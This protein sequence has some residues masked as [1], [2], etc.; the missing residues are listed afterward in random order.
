MRRFLV[1]L[2]AVLTFTPSAAAAPVFF[3]EGRGWGH[4]IGMPQYGAYGY[5]REEGR[6]YA[7]ILGHYYRGTTLG[8][9]SVDAVRVLLADDRRSLTV[10]SEAAFTAV[11][12]NGRELEFPAGRRVELAPDLRVTVAGDE[13]RLAG[14]VRFVRGERPL[15]LGGRPYRGQLVIRSSG[16]TLSA[17]NYVGLEEY[18]YGVVP[19][20]MPPEWPMEALKAQ[21]VAA[22]SYA[23]VSRRTGGVFDLF[24]DTRSQ[25]YNG[26]GA[27]EPRTNAAIDATA[28]RVVVYEGRVAYTFFHSTSG[29]RTAAIHDVW[30]AARVPYL[31]SVADPY[32]RLSPY[33]RWGP[34]RYTGAQLARRLGSAAPPGALRDAAVVR[35]PSDRA[36]RVVLRGTRGSAAISG[37]GFQA[38]LDL[39]SSWFS[40]AVLSL[41]GTPR[42]SYGAG[43]AL[44]GIAR[45]PSRVS[46]EARAWGGEWARVRTLRAA[47]GGAFRTAVRP[48]ITTWYRLSARQGKGAA[49][50]VAV[51]PRVTLAAREAGTL[52]G[53]VHPLRSGIHVTIERRTATGWTTVARA[54]TSEGGRFAATLALEAGSYRAVARAGRGYVPGRSRTVHVGTR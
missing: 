9:T 38:R 2:L 6:S 16:G 32:D 25:V 27:E 52:T 17:V 36:E 24:A 28:G 11:D 15:E 34:L 5:A 42:V 44:R 41:S 22:R 40:I 31:V 45:G 18:L 54:T 20:E 14:P 4:G 37:D 51:A 21:A 19:D 10:S 39:R 1:P 13:R 53:V 33:H 50:R 49:V 29:G 47:S 35:N 7:W 12:A 8:S 26:I 48:S 30:N 23:V 43:A 3:V 46:L